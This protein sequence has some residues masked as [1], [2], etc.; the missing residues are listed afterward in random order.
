MRKNSENF[1]KYQLWCIRWLYGRKKDIKAISHDSLRY[2]VTC[3]CQPSTEACD[4]M[5]RA[6]TEIQ[7]ASLKENM[8]LEES[9]L[10]CIRE[11][12]QCV[13]SEQMLSAACILHYGGNEQL[14]HVESVFPFLFWQGEFA[15]N[16]FSLTFC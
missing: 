10:G 7:Y 3:Q 1:L 4:S 11:R 12:N 15:L 14:H 13:D 6:N 8:L 9:L 5:L 16:C 2:V